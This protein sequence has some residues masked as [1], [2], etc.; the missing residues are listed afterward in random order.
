[1]DMCTR[2]FHKNHFLF[3][4]TKRNEISPLCARPRVFSHIWR[5]LNSIVLFIFIFIFIFIFKEE[6]S[7]KT[8]HIWLVCRQKLKKEKKLSS[9][10]TDR[11]WANWN[12]YDIPILSASSI[13][14]CFIQL[15]V[16]VSPSLFCFKTIILFI[17]LFWLV[18]EKLLRLTFSRLWPVKNVSS[19]E[20]CFPLSLSISLFLQTY[21]VCDFF[22]IQSKTYGIKSRSNILFGC[23][24]HLAKAIWPSLWLVPSFGFAFAVVSAMVFFSTRIPNF[25]RQFHL[26]DYQRQLWCV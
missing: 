26:R 12:G 5:S 17:C 3:T 10:K 9:W 14:L 13:F 16:F 8:D 2:S 19:F 6:A 15:S 4:W 11:K 21:N 1:M 22:E 7:N 20:W 24:W 23:D 25:T 18:F